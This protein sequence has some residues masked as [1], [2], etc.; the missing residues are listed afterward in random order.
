VKEIDFLP[1]RIVLEAEWRYEEEWARR[2]EAS[3]AELGAD[4]DPAVFHEEAC[5]ALWLRKVVTREK[6]GHVHA[7]GSQALLCAWILRKVCGVTVSASIEEAPALPAGCIEILT[8]C[9]EGDGFGWAAAGN[10]R[11]EILSRTGAFVSAQAQGSFCAA[12]G[13]LFAASR[14]TGRAEGGEPQT[15]VSRGRPAVR[16]AMTDKSFSDVMWAG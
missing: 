12:I 5:H 10:G 3:R 13:S 11:D 1:E 14:E 2:I 4:L 16:Y 8:A 7:A 15:K 6:I 9:C